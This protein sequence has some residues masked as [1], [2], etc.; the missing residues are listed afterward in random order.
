MTKDQIRANFYT[1]VHGFMSS[2]DEE[3]LPFLPGLGD[4]RDSSDPVV[5]ARL[6]MVIDALVDMACS[7]AEGAAYKSIRAKL[8]NHVDEI[9]EHVRASQEEEANV[10]VLVVR[11]PV[12]LPPE[13]L[14]EA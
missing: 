13:G 4:L 14:P 11:A 2:M 7:G 6:D 9:R 1:I 10:E 8:M 12:I 3:I 5:Q